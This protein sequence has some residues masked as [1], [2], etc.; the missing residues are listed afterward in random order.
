MR[1]SA[2]LAQASPPQSLFE[3]ACRK[4]CSLDSVLSAL[5]IDYVAGAEFRQAKEARPRNRL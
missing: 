5:V 2:L 1:V 3:A 4:D